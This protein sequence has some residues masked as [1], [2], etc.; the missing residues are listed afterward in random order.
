MKS[1][2]TLGLAV[3]A[4]LLL[5]SCLRG[6]FTECPIGM[7]SDW[8]NNAGNANVLADGYGEVYDTYI[9][10]E[11]KGAPKLDTN[12]C[13]KTR[14]Y[15]PDPYG[16]KGCQSFRCDFDR[17]AGALLKAADHQGERYFSVPAATAVIW[18]GSTFNCQKS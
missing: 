2:V 10:L 11:Q 18:D 5:S 1:S 14:I 12:S 7:A 9:K 13:V 3:S 16:E 15:C 8:N 4:A 6:G 17:P